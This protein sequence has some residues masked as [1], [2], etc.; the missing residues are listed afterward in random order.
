MRAMVYKSYGSQPELAELPRPKP[1]TGQ[2]L[3]A[4]RSSSVN[5][6][7][8]KV[9]R[10]DMRMLTLFPFPRVPGLD[11]AGEIVEIGAGVKGFVVGQ[12][13]H[14]RLGDLKGGACAEVALVGVDVLTGMPQGMD[15]ATAA[16]LPLAGMTA[17]QGLRD[18]CGLPLTGATQRVLIVG[19]SGGVGHLG[20]QIAASTGAH[21][22]GVCSGRN[23]ELVRGL[24]AHEVIDYTQ[25]DAY[26]GQAPFDVI[27]DCVGGPYAPWLP[28]LRSDGHFASVVPGP[29][30]IGRSLLNLVSG[31][32]VHPVLLKANAAD[33]ALLDGLFAAGKLRCV[34]DSHFSLDQLAQ[35]W[36]RS[37]S[38][39]ATGKIVIDV[40]A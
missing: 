37:I 12:K 5:P 15:F 9:A 14:A 8:W 4:V 6:V 31:Q 39:R 2:V 32:K 22:T 28:R 11:V 23:T 40:S 25:P 29:A 10:G 30:V 24:G 13:V 27:L 38:G 26:A 1:A 21:V 18:A 33:L 16:A 7:D 17:L 3:V 35:A 36:T 34:I 20:V 19:A